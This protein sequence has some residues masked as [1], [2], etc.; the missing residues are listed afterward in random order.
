MYII[1]LKISNILT[2]LDTL[3]YL[4]AKVHLPRLYLRSVSSWKSD[5]TKRKD[6]N[7]LTSG[8]SRGYGTMKTQS[9]KL[10]DKHKVSKHFLLHLCYMRS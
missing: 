4:T 6:L 8:G 2:S 7:I 9:A 1:N 3:T 5:S 10:T